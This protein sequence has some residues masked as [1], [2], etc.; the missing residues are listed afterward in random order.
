MMLCDITPVRSLAGEEAI[1]SM[2]CAVARKRSI[3]AR[4]RDVV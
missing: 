1:T 3:M 2:F 4:Q